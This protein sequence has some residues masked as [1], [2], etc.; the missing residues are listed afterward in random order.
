MH[1]FPIICG[2]HLNRIPGTAIEKCSV[3]SLADAFLT[4][5]A[6][7]WINFDA[8]EWR[9]VFVRDPE[10]AGFNRAILDARRR[11]RASGA[12]ISGNRKYSWSLLAG[13]LAVAF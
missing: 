11:T 3:G 7:I 5:D 10:H 1:S 9:M 2:H 6:E 4:A 8:S 12:T 13:G